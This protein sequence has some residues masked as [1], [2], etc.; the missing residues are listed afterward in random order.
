[1]HNR[2]HPQS[3]FNQ[4]YVSQVRCQLDQEIITERAEM[5]VFIYFFPP[6]SINAAGKWWR[7]DNE[8][9]ENS[10]YENIFSF[11]IALSQK[12]CQVLSTS[13]PPK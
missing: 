12:M 9:R 1:M 7:N 10:C 2:L 11:F 6:L 13:F 3:H 4:R 5:Y 8:I